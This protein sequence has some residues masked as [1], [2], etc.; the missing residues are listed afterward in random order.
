MTDYSH[1]TA[2]YFDKFLHPEYSNFVNPFAKLDYLTELESD[3]KKEKLDLIRML[4]TKR[5]IHRILYRMKSTVW[6]FYNFSFKQF[7][8]S[9]F[10]VEI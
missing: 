2:N 1:I 9:I 6:S 10:F 4:D 7:K 5:P 3:I 8:Q